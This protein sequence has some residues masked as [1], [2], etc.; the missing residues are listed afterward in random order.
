VKVALDS[1]RQAQKGIRLHNAFLL[2]RQAGDEVCFLQ[3]LEKEPLSDSSK[4]GC[5]MLYFLVALLDKWIELIS[6]GPILGLS[7]AENLNLRMSVGFGLAYYLIGAVLLDYKAQH[8]HE[9]SKIM[10][11]IS[12]KSAEHIRD[13]AVNDA[14][15]KQRLYWRTLGMFLSVHVWALGVTSALI[16]MLDGS[17]ECLIIF[18]S[19]VGAYSGLILYQ[20]IFLLFLSNASILSNSVIVQQN[21]L[22]TTCFSSP[23]W[24]IFNRLSYWYPSKAC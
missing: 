4:I 8:L 17:K 2:W 20:V 14:K 5:T 9:L 1:L 13:A 16:W 7:D 10:N 15:A 22:R 24:R 6:G 19:Y 12:I 3:I 18:L 21:L 11:P 23:T